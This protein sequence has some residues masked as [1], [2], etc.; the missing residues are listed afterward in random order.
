MAIES[1]YA[2]AIA[3]RS[4]W[5]KRLAPVFQP[6][7]SKTKTNRTT[8]AW[9][10]RALRELQIIAR[11]CDWFLVLFAS[12]EI[13]RNNCFGFGFGFWTVIWKPLDIISAILLPNEQNHNVFNLMLFWCLHNCMPY[14]INFYLFFFLFPSISSCQLSNA[15][16][17]HVFLI[18]SVVIYWHVLFK[19]S[20]VNIRLTCYI[21]SLK[22]L[23]LLDA[24]SW[25]KCSM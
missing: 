9:F 20:C 13:G 19:I 14:W 25:S 2:I 8:Y 17:E 16:G 11:K 22:C 5:L 4:D 12:V 24:S 18:F 7:R 6:T 1:N 21:F 3:T 23:W 15:G 10:S